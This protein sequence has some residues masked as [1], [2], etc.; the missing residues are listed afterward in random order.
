MALKETND[1]T[2]DADVLKAP[3]PVVVDFWAEWCGSCKAMMPHLEAA[4]A[5]LD[6]KVTVYKLNIEDAIMTAGKLGI[7][8]VPTMML[9]KD[10]KLAD[11]KVGALSRSKIDDWLAQQ[12]A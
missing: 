7:R 12:L 8:G 9:F 5:D 11:T 3:G 1:D 10:G 2:F 6:G 4:A